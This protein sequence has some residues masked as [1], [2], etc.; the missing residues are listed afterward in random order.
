MTDIPLF[1]LYALFK[2]S[3]ICEKW[4]ALDKDDFQINRLIPACGEEQKK[5]FKHLFEKNTNFFLLAVERE[6]EDE[7]RLLCESATRDTEK[8]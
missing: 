6:C 7:I 1:A 5:Q 4:F 3:F 2:P 8:E